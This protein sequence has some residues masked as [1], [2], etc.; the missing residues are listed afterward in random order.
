VKTFIATTSALVG[1]AA[2][3]IVVAPPAEASPFAN[4]VTI[5]KR[6]T[7]FSPNG[8]GRH[9]TDAIRFTMLKGARVTARV[10]DQDGRVLGP[11]RLGKVEPGAHTW[12][13]DGR[14]SE[15]HVVPDGQYVVT[16]T[17]VRGKFT[18]VVTAT[19]LVRS[20]P[21]S[22][23][24]L[25][26]RLTVYP[27]ATV[28]HDRVQLVYVPQDYWMNQVHYPHLRLR[29]RFVVRDER[30]EVIL[31]STS[32][33]YA[34]R[35]EWDGRVD[36]VP[37]PAGNYVVGVVITDSVGN[38]RALQSELTVADAQLAEQTWTAGVAA[39]SAATYVT[40]SYP[41]GK[42]EYYSPG[43]SY[44]MW[45]GLSFF[46]SGNVGPLP[47]L[48][49]FAADAPVPEAP[50]DTYRVTATGGPTV[51]GS[52]DVGWLSAGS[53]PAMQ[54]ATGDASIVTPWSTV[55]LFRYPYLPDGYRPMTWRFWTEGGQGYDVSWFT[56][57]YR[58][59]VRVAG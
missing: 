57:E 56:L 54:T 30:G 13:W 52:T 6:M 7:F 34:P 44:R 29:A 2:T 17:A 53:T 40:S 37:A 50:V 24:L 14:D 48:A 32:G 27:R 41:G 33:S 49:D 22:G 26:G 36:G 10:A 59:Y 21:D 23:R 18:D 47:V 39:G 4:L 46:V 35:F 38:V 28:V 1:L 51:P 8:D 31:R 58:Y 9:D 16:L 12:R 43:P 20:H 15:G 3:G 19:P 11:V 25:A 45:G 42:Y 5:T 55:D